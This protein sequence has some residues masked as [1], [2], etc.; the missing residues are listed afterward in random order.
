MR[1]LY[2]LIVLLLSFAAAQG[3]N[4]GGAPCENPKYP[5]NR[6]TNKPPVPPADWRAPQSAV[7]GVD[8][9]IDT[10]GKVKNA[11]VVYSGGKDVD[12]SV[13][14]AVRNWAYVPAMCGTTPV[15]MTIHVKMNLVGREKSKP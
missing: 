6:I 2:V 9:T 3:Q 14:Q 4:P 8:L 5:V 15:E 12:E 10:N 1:K 7:V 13:L 11:V